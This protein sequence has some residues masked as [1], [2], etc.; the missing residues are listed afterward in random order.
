MNIYDNKPVVIPTWEL[1]LVVEMG[2]YQEDSWVPDQTIV[3]FDF[4]VYFDNKKLELNRITGTHLV[5]MPD[6]VD[7]VNHEL[8]L[9]VVNS[10]WEHLIK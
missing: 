6:T 4:E 3:P 7:I 9:V 8:K 5:N 2:T 1:K 10:H